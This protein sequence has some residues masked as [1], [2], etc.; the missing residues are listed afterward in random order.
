MKRLRVIEGYKIKWNDLKSNTQTLENKKEFKK[1]N[2]TLQYWKKNFLKNH[3]K[4]Q[5]H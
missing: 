3:E 1:T 2:K 4:N 5:E